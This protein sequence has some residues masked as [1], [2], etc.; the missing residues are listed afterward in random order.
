MMEHDATERAVNRYSLTGEVFYNIREKI[1]SG[2]YKPNEELKENTLATNL[3]VSRTPVREALRQLEFEGLVKIIPNKGAFV[4]GI[5]LKDIRDIYEMRSLLEG[6][7][8]RKACEHATKELLDKLDENIDL[9]EFYCNKGDFEKVVSLDNEFHHL[10]YEA[11]DSKLL[12]SH[13]TD[14]HH[15]LERIRKTTLTEKSR[16]FTSMVEHRAIIEA[17]KKGDANEAEKLAN[18]HIINAMQNIKD[19]GL[20]S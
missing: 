19:H 20:W 11:S 8:A 16:A 14:F 15:Y 2:E 18:T 12:K 7:C 17:I 9:S 1:L 4:L 3:G 13:L 10:L 5:S 6:L